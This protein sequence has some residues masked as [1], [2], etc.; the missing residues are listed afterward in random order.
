LFINIRKNTCND[1]LN[2][3][4]PAVALPCALPYKYFANTLSI[5]SILGTVFIPALTLLIRDYSVFYSIYLPKVSSSAKFVTTPNAVRRDTNIF[6]HYSSVSLKYII[7]SNVICFLIYFIYTYI[8]T[9]HSS[10][11]SFCYPMLI[12]S[13]YRCVL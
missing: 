7:K 1:F 11:G 10:Y 3:S 9:Y 6:S 4:V 12:R 13:V 2:P 8:H 5:F